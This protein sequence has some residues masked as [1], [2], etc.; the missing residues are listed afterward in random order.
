MF[1]TTT[2]P[3][4]PLVTTVGIVNLVFGGLFIAFG[5]YCLLAGADAVATLF[6]A[7]D[8][9][10]KAGAAAGVTVQTED[11]KQLSALADL[12]TKGLSGVIMAMVGVVAGCSIIQGTPLLLVGAGV[13][14]R[15]QWARV[16]A[17]VFAVLAGLE[18]LACL[19]SASQSRTFLVSGIVLLAYA[20]LSFVGLLG[21]R[22]SADFSG[23]AD[24]Y[25][26]QRAS[27]R[28]FSGETDAASGPPPIPPAER[29]FPAVPV[30]AVLLG[31]AIIALGVLGYLFFTSPS[32]TAPG[33]QAGDAKTGKPPVSAPIAKPADWLPDLMAAADGGQLSRI[34]E[35]AAKGPVDEKN[36]QGETALM[37]AA[38]KGNVH[39]SALL[40]ALGAQV[41]EHDNKGQTP[42]ML[43][44]ENG[45]GP[46]VD[47]FLGNDSGAVDFNAIRQQAL[48]SV[49]IDIDKIRKDPLNGPV[50]LPPLEAFK[51]PHADVNSRDAEGQTAFMK[52][53]LNG[54]HDVAKTLITHAVNAA[55][56]DHEGN[57]VVHLAAQKGDIDVVMHFKLV[58]W[59]D[60][61]G[62]HRYY[63]PDLGS[64]ASPVVIDDSPNRAGLQPWMLA[65]AAGRLACLKLLLP[66]DASKDVVNEKDKDGKT[67]LDLAAANGH[68][69]VVEFLKPLAGM[70]A[71]VVVAQPPPPPLP[72]PEPP[73]KY[74]P[75]PLMKAVDAGDLEAVQSILKASGIAAD[76]NDEKGQTVLMHAAAKGEAKIV[77]LLA[78]HAGKALGVEYLER[79]DKE[80]RTALIHAA[81][82]GHAAAVEALLFAVS[83]EWDRGRLN[84][85]T[86]LSY[87]DKSGKSALEQ[88]E[89]KND[90]S[91]VEML[92]AYVKDNLNVR[93]TKNGKTG[94]EDMCERG[95]LAGVD[96]LLKFGA[97]KSPAPSN[98]SALALAAGK[99]HSRIVQALLDSFGEDM[100]GRKEYVALG[101]AM[102]IPGV[103]DRPMTAL[104]AAVE[105][106][107]IVVVQEL[108]DAFGD[109]KKARKACMQATT[110]SVDPHSGT[111]DT[112][113]ALTLANRGNHK[114]IAAMLRKFG[115]TP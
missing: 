31:A 75:S 49:P 30:L 102:P 86:P 67:A 33:Q 103:G 83:A 51:P 52:A 108:L 9:V 47:L 101:V 21:R 109:D 22:A 35:A 77:L 18:G 82:A 107:H 99:G 59:G 20:V 100:A 94:L 44:A 62:P 95:N 28:R 39:A 61:R 8:E 113:P 58:D 87:K 91:T 89:A 96:A 7:K 12:G 16:L 104:L 97:D 13:L 115:A 112:V 114:E 60:G 19:S 64:N 37:K 43:A 79:E 80:G 32:K 24:P 98:M 36:E 69:D 88:A 38:A 56:M 42:L 57:N 15:R 74:E 48:V 25:A 4:S 65:A 90:K 40:L 45:H 11:A 2:R 6:Q 71:P 73:A 53:V 76:D 78:A 17:L 14:A 81:A 55:A 85:F 41:N 3:R 93:S 34:L 26:G 27:E 110:T 63:M 84:W 1:Q 5:A 46:V 66:A 10:A 23:R 106:G 111:P 54:H 70:D 50:N 68:K 29:R 72:A 92:R 105:N